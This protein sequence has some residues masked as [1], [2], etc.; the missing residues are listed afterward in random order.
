MKNYVLIIYAII[1]LFLIVAVPLVTLNVVVNNQHKII[2][3][4]HN[5]AELLKDRK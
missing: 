5:I 2:E 3:N 1:L 4:Q